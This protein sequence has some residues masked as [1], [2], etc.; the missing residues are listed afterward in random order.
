MTRIGKGKTVLRIV[1]D[2]YLK[3][4][5]CMDE[6]IRIDNHENSKDRVFNVVLS[7]VDFSNENVNAYKKYWEDKAIELIKSYDKDFKDVIR[8]EMI[9]Q[10]N[11]D[12]NLFQNIM[13]FID[14][15]MITL[16]DQIYLPLEAS[17]FENS[18][19]KLVYKGDMGA[20]NSFVESLLNRAKA[21]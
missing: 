12:V 17:S 14:Q 7:D 20:I 15:F 16:R 9:K 19:G 8:R 11:S 5:Y 13:Q 21:K 4:K 18:D 6:A 3:S 1:S 10:S 2:K